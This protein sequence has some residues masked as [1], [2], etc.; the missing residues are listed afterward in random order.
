MSPHST[1]LE[2]IK[3]IRQIPLSYDTADSD[4]SARKLIF[5]LLPDW[6]YDEG[7]VELIRFTD[8]ITNTVRCCVD[9]RHY[10]LD[11]AKGLY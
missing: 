9:I 3:D 11:S 10:F 5:A 8:G 2:A 6:E 1:T 7:E 4:V